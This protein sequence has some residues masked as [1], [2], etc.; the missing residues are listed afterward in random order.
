MREMGTF[1]N[2]TRRIAS[3]TAAVKP[4]TPGP[5]QNSVNLSTYYVVSISGVSLLQFRDF[6]TNGLKLPVV[7]FLNLS[8]ALGV[9]RFQ[10]AV[11]LYP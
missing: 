5:S 6:L 1:L 9:I 7:F 10:V 2:P 8:E 4:S 11:H 3:S